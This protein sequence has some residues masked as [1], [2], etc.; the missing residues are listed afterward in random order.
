MDDFLDQTKKNHRFA[1]ILMILFSL[2]LFPVIWELPGMVLRLLQVFGKIQSKQ[3][4][5]VRGMPGIMQVRRILRLWPEPGLGLKPWNLGLGLWAHPWPWARAA[6][7][8]GSAQTPRPGLQRS[9]QTPRPGLQSFSPR[10]GPGQSLGIQLTCVMPDMSR[11]FII[12]A[13]WILLFRA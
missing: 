8:L 1:R 11:A 2:A 9:A 7:G 13:L 10:P 4:K 3:I 12:C 6:A 5:N